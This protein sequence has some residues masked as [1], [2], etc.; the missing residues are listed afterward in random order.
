MTRARLLC[1]LV[2]S[3]AWPASGQ[4][5]ARV[6]TGRNYAVIPPGAGPAEVIRIAAHVAPSP[7]QLAWQG[8]EFIAFFHFGMNTFTNREWGTGR[9]SPSLFNPTDFDARQWVRAIRDAG[10]RGVIITAKHHDGFCLWPSRYTDHTIRNSPWRDGK[11]DVVGDVASACREYGVAFGF[12]LSPW[13]RHEPTYGDSPKYNEFFRNQL[14]ELLTSYGRIAEV[15]FDGACGEGPNG[16]R[17]VY[18][19]PSYYRLVRELQPGAVIA[20]MGPDVRWVGTE[21]GYG[22][23]TEWSVVP[24]VVVNLDSIAASSQ[25][26]A[27][28]Q[29]FVP[30]D[31]T[32]EDLGSR[33]KILHARSLLWYPAETDVSIRPGWFYHADQDTQVKSPE[34]LVDIYYSSVGRN[35]VLLLNIPPDTRGRITDA[36]VRSLAGMRNIL[37]ATFRTN[38]AADA[39]VTTT[40]ARPGHGGSCALDPGGGALDP[41]GGTYWIT[42]E[43]VCGGT[44]TCALPGERTF[45]R[46]MLGENIRIGQRVEEFH[47]DAMVGGAWRRVAGGTTIGYRRL[48][49]FPAVTTSNLRLVIDRARW[50]PAISTFGVYRAPAR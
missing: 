16:K 40:S 39:R 17:Q 2:L 48:L 13:D 37:D 14:R 22:R 49:R 41:G 24:D 7:R 26:L 21:S 10:M 12:Y 30:R 44:L 19:W 6:D 27:L 33:E 15:W 25:H 38:L 50:S 8:R 46:A 9:E 3:L 34:T 11:G 5:P 36:D 4:E 29:G 42:E 43:G 28:E 20:V 32:A 31:L 23:E 45:D 47:I 1:C 35:S 18:D